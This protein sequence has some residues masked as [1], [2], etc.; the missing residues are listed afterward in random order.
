MDAKVSYI[1]LTDLPDEPHRP[2]RLYMPGTAAATAL[3]LRQQR[4]QV[5]KR[6]QQLS[7]PKTRNSNPSKALGTQTR[8]QSTL[9]GVGKPRREDDDS[10]RAVR[11]IAFSYAPPNGTAKTCTTFQWD[12]GGKRKVRKVTLKRTGD[13]RFTLL[14]SE[15]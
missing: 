14:D 5:R 13:Q 15:A 3:A 6:A 2:L 4:R 1:D 12:N 8:R 7:A 11:V 9:T 10:Y